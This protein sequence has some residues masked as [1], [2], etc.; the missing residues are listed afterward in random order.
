M[1]IVRYRLN[2]RRRGSFARGHVA[3]QWD[4]QGGDD[5]CGHDR[6]KVVG[7]GEGRGLAIGEQPELFQSGNVA[8]V[9]TARKI[10]IAL[11]EGSDQVGVATRISR[12]TGDRP[13]VS[14]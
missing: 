4:E 7:I 9:E 13:W 5:K 12:D 3:Q 6:T 8:P 11:C 1:H 14:R 2:A 10:R